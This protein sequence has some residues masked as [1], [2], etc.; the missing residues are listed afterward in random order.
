MNSA[1]TK[2][3]SVAVSFG[4]ISPDDY[5][6][7]LDKY[8]DY[9]HD[10][11]FSPTES[12]RYQT[13]NKIYD[14]GTTNN[15]ERRQML[16]QVLSYARSSG[17]ACSMTLNAP[18]VSA[19]EQAETFKSYNSLYQIDQLTTTL[20]IGK[21]VREQGANIPMICSY[22]EAITNRRH[23]LNVLDSG[24]FQIVVLGG[25]FSR[26]LEVFNLIKERGVKTVLMLNTG[27]C[28]NCVSFCKVRNQN[29][30]RDL[31][32][33]NAA[34]MGV[35]T[36]YAAQSIFPEEIK[37][38]YLP[39]GVVDIFKLASRPIDKEELNTLIESYVSLDSKSYVSRTTRNYHLYG[40]LAHF[41]PYY[42]EFDYDRIVDMKRSLWE[43]K[44]STTLV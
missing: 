30:C 9:I 31:F 18:M 8:K 17:I 1:L 37:D 11:F 26:D 39:S 3:F 6:A 41:V 20:E 28:M 25:R 35:E 12:L 21:L 24:L 7:V 43:G 2:K 32:N 42:E 10:I 4:L 19:E 14:F 13:R 33:D 23:L 44:A 27:C 16:G 40:R 36:M 38:Y 5:I 29:Y 15:D 34:Q 22:N